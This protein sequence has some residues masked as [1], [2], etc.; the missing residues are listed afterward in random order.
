MPFLQFNNVSEYVKSSLESAKAKKKKES[1]SKS[2]AEVFSSNQIADDK[3]ASSG[4]SIGSGSVGSVFDDPAPMTGN[5][6][7]TLIP[8]QTTAQ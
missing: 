8:G 7:A 2:V 4:V 6:E 5:E 1:E 3:G